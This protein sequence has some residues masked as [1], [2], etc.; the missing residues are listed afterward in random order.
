LQRF[1]KHATSPLLGEKNGAKIGRTSSTAVK[2][3]EEINCNPSS[4]YK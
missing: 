1:A 3:V 2:N 4:P